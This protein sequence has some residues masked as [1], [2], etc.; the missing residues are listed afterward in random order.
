MTLSICW[1]VSPSSMDDNRL[2]Y[3]CWILPK[4]YS[5]P[6]NLLLGVRMVKFLS[7][8]LLLLFFFSIYTNKGF[9]VLI[10]V[11]VSYM[12]IQKLFFI[13]HSSL[14]SFF[15]WLK[16]KCFI[17]ILA[18]LHSLYYSSAATVTMNKKNVNHVC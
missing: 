18:C 9:D 5:S 1:W 12:N 16:S 6:Q 3:C 15:S 8:L 14:I 17:P 7:I 2:I 4:T 10:A 13:F 11:G